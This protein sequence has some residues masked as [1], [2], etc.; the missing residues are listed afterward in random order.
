MHVIRTIA[1]LAAFAFTVSAG[2]AAAHGPGGDAALETVRE[3]S[4]AAQESL[5]GTVHEF[6]VADTTRGTSQRYVELQL[7]D[8]SLVALQG[9]LADTLVKDSRVEVSGI[10]RG[11]PLAVDTVRSLPGAPA[12]TA[13]A[14][15]EVD[16][17]LAILHADYF[18]DGSS[19]FVFEVHQASGKVQQL[20]LGS[21]PATL[22]PGMKVRVLGRAE[23][24]GESMIPDRITVLARASTSDATQGAVT[25]AATAN[26]VLV[27]MANFQ[28]TAAPAL[29]SAQAQQVMTSNAD[30]VANFFRE[31]SYGQQVMNVTVTPG[32]SAMNL[33]QPT[34]CGSTDW[35]A[36]GTAADA[37]AK[38]WGAAYDPTAYNFVVYVFPAVPACGW[39][40]LAYINS[41][42]KA[43]I[44]G[45]GAF[46]TSTIVHE[47][48]H[49]Y[50][51][52]HAASLRCTGAPIG[53]SCAASEYGDPFGAMGNQ[54]AM[55]YSA[56][57]KSKLGWIPASTVLTHTGGS[58][59][60]TLSPLEL[61]GGATY[62]VKIPTAASNRTYWLE[63]RQPIGF[64]S[65]LSG[66]PNNGAQVRVANP[67][68]TLCSGC[69]TYS[70]DTEL[71]DMTPSTSSFTDATLPV[72]ST[73]SDPSYGINV[74][75]L[76]ATASAMTVRVG[77]GG[78]L[79]TT[80]TSLASSA[81]PSISG[82]AITLTA[83]V[84][85]ASPT[86][87]VTFSLG[88][89][90]A[91]PLSGTGNA[92]SAA[93]GVSG[94]SSGTYVVTA[95]Y[96]GDAANAAS[97][98][99]LTQNVQSTLLPASVPVYRFNTGAYHFYTNSESEKNYVLAN[100][101]SW[102]LEGV[103]FYAD[104]ASS[105]QTAPVY[106]FNTGTFHFYTISENEKNYILANLP[107]YVLEGIAFYASQ[108]SVSQ[109]LPVY[110]FNTGTEHF[111]TISANEK[112]YVLANLP[113][114]K[115]EGIAFYARTSP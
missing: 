12:T 79:A 109:T 2:I 113:G 96:S 54:R 65:P 7:A 39:I 6:V 98:G 18:V 38:G 45:V 68:E 106:R 26:S 11:K 89:C 101:P 47:M 91:V 15:M 104:A 40:G 14:V 60:Y 62:A 22:E 23:P 70:D 1:A 86:G 95:T 55:H 80:T 110:R 50:G 59:T 27:V 102:N 56:R 61:S 112:N 28:N 90:G 44:N 82:S 78:A 49:N 53:G 83:T 4:V 17:T 114:Y 35:K 107:N 71:L 41:P 85:G 29:T 33:A 30:S 42:H 88:S 69:D 87:S 108:T 8:G 58:A 46:R 115:L 100:F 84:T 32:W 93:C 24:D 105:P 92:R 31:T 72:G 57:Q 37:A 21:M 97:T 19:T 43:W 73:F 103:A 25:K 81:N 94:L 66:F 3:P 99:S 63:F 48:G 20:H 13:K 76:S 64:D 52:L 5:A 34:T 9:P 111:Y 16:G 10:R 51:L 74:T 36:I 75:V 77:T 67:F